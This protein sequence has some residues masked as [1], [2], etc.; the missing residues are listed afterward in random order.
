MAKRAGGQSVELALYRLREMVSVR[1]SGGME[2]VV[3]AHE[4]GSGEWRVK[5]R[6]RCGM[7]RRECVW[8]QRACGAMA[9]SDLAGVYGRWRM[10]WEATVHA[11]IGG[12]EQTGEYGGKVTGNAGA[13]AGERLRGGGVAER[14]SGRCS[15]RAWW[16]AV[17]S[18]EAKGWSLNVRVV[19]ERLEGERAAPPAPWRAGRGGERATGGRGVRAQRVCAVCERALCVAH[20]MCSAVRSAVGAAWV[21]GSARCTLCE[22]RC[23]ACGHG[24]RAAPRLPVRARPAPPSCGRGRAARGGRGRATGR[25]WVL[26]IALPPTPPSLPTH[27]HPVIRH[28][29]TPRYPIHCDPLPQFPR[30]PRLH[31]F[32]LHIAW[33]GGPF[34]LWFSRKGSR[35]SELGFPPVYEEALKASPNPVIPRFLLT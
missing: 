28:I 8:K 17:T 18:E 35:L 29:I 32:A 15:A 1:E 7:R 5:W 3:F 14:A 33:R 13:M 34:P 4:A 12:M 26:E 20:G 11:W 10:R 9:E 27:P 23:A 24:R 30:A 21:G 16:M 6:G 25:V 31:A 19:R 22:A 2:I